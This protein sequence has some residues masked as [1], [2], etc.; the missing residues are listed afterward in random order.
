[1]KL[2][3]VFWLTFREASRH[4]DIDNPDPLST[5]RDH[6]AIAAAVA[7][8]H[9]PEAREALDAHYAGLTRRLEQAQARLHRAENENAAALTGKD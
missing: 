4:T 2:L 9:V 8:G 6:A 1:L 7:A 3:D 5:Y